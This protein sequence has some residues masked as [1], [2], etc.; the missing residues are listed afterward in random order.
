[1]TNKKMQP[2]HSAQGGEVRRLVRQGRKFS[3]GSPVSRTR[4]AE[5]PVCC[6]LDLVL[7]PFRN[8]AFIEPFANGR[9]LASGYT[10]DFCLCSVE[11]E[12]VVWCHV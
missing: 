2:N 11:L 7:L 5:L 12:K 9:Q 8:L 6:K 4:G 1:M 3:C 10:G